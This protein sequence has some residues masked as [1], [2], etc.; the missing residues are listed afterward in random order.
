M[1]RVDLITHLIY[2]Q[3][4]AK[5]RFWCRFKNRAQPKASLRQCPNYLDTAVIAFSS[6]W[7]NYPWRSIGD[8]KGYITYIY[9]YYNAEEA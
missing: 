6:V 1:D 7:L 9:M 3:Y 2:R 5:F 4:R 8:G